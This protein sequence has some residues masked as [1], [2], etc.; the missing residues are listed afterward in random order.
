MAHESAAEAAVS[1][2]CLSRFET[3]AEFVR[4]LDE[5]IGDDDTLLSDLS[6]R[7][8]QHELGDEMAPACLAQLSRRGVDGA[9]YRIGDTDRYAKYSAMISM[10][11]GDHWN[12]CD[13]YDMDEF[14]GWMEVPDARTLEDLFVAVDRFDFVFLLRTAI[15]LATLQGV[16]AF[17]EAWSVEDEVLCSTCEGVFDDYTFIMTGTA[18]VSLPSGRLLRE[19]AVRDIDNDHIR[20]ATALCNRAAELCSD[21]GY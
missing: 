14:W 3:V 4:F 21:Y 20:H 16:R 9:Q 15:H 5:V 10:M 7:I 12:W 17:F 8:L 2:F 19:V 13:M 18:R 6:A 11:Y 1:E